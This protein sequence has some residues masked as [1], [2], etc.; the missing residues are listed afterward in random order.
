MPSRRHLV[1]ALISLTLVFVSIWSVAPSGQA[2]A[3]GG[4]TVFEGARL[5]NGEGDA[6]IENASFV[7]EGGRFVQV[8]RA[9]DVRVP[10][11]ATRVSLAGKTVM[12][13]IVDTHSH[14][15]PTRDALITDLQRRAY[16]GI[17]A[18]MSL[19]QD[20]GTDAFTVRAAALPGIPRY[21]TAG[22]GITLPEPGRSEAPYWVTSEAEARK[23]VQELAALKVDIVKI[24]VDD[25][26]D[27]YRKLPPEFS[28]AIIDEAHRHGLRVTAHI[29]ELDDA[30]GLLRAGIDAFSHGVRDRDIDEE[31]LA[32]FKARPN[33][34]VVPNLP[35]R[36]VA[37]DMSWLRGSIPAAEI[38]KLQA[39]ATDRPAVQPL[40]AVQAR[41][42]VKLN[43]AGT[44]LALGTDGNTPWAPHLEMADMVA[45]GMTPAQVIVAA[46]RNGAQFLRI[47]D[48]GTIA[49]GKSADFIVLDANPLDE[50]TNTRRISAVY[51]R[52]TAVDRT[53]YR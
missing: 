25:R 43:A 39:G 19:G 47:P 32:L 50:I 35:D 13:A 6:P 38:E 21:F 36:G 33:F 15:N 45:A 8:G 4:I 49:S 53:S 40:F 26:D 30:K 2:P 48:A 24:W 28:A 27:M 34:V 23:A 44:R 5:I 20:T 22:R 10:A 3:A 14:P 17:G 18:V 9:G 37:T 51:L 12:P 46:T 16:F 11:G 31:G 1:A 41:N 42:L 7:I 52:G 29:F